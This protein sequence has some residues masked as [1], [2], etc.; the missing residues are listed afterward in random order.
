MENEKRENLFTT[1][2]VT[3]ERYCVNTKGK[4][5]YE[6]LQGI[7]KQLD[8]ALLECLDYANADSSFE[9]DE[10]VYRR[11][12]VGCRR[13]IVYTVRGSN[14]GFYLHVDMVLEGGVLRNLL[15]FKTLDWT[16]DNIKKLEAAV[17]KIVDEWE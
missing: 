1:Y 7:Q 11:Y 8:P 14:E 9:N 13:V 3:P 6:I 10:T 4:D 17:W 5:S 2:E 16:P 15:L 12:D